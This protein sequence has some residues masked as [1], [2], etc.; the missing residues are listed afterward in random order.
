M[1]A[2]DHLPPF[3]MPRDWRPAQPLQNAHLNFVRLE[4][5]QSVKSSR[6]ALQRFAWEAG[7]QIGVNVNSRALP[8][9]LKIIA[10]ALVI[11]AA[12]DEAADIRI[13]RLNADLEL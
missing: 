7:D 10:Q 5:D 6:K 13:K 3:V 9:K 11:L 1:T 8:Q 12:F 2:I 4:P